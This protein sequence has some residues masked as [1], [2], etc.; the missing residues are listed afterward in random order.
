MHQA[1]GFLVWVETVLSIGFLATK[2]RLIQE[3]VKALMQM[4]LLVVYLHQY[5]ID[6]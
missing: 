3:S 6:Y 4:L 2:V 1:N 5:F